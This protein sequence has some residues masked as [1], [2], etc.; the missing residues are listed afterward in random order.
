MWKEQGKDDYQ[1]ELI[2]F[3][4]LLNA[5]A[6]SSVKKFLY[7]SSTEAIGPVIGN[8]PADES[9]T[10]NPTYGILNYN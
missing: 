9:A 1:F 8:N 4:N 5:C 2:T 6:Q 7:C 10:C 3:R